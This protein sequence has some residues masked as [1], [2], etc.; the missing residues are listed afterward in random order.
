MSL[1]GHFKVRKYLD[2]NVE[3]FWVLPHGAGQHGYACVI[4]D[5]LDGENGFQNGASSESDGYFGPR[6]SRYGGRG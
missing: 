3:D 2:T 1:R 4:L 5:E 6:G